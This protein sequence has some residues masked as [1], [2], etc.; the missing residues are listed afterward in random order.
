MINKAEG[1]LDKAAKVGHS[2]SRCVRGEGKIR[3]CP[4]PLQTE[5][6]LCDSPPRPNP[7]GKAGPGGFSQLFPSR[8]QAP[9][10]ARTTMANREMC[11][12]CGPSTEAPKNKGVKDPDPF[13]NSWVGPCACHACFKNHLHLDFHSLHATATLLLH[14][15]PQLHRACLLPAPSC[16]ASPTSLRVAL[17]LTKTNK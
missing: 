16:P 7:A 11:P 2:S 3:R 17:V 12:R 10:D 1:R 9:C 4:V 5:P 14:K 15:G 8:A 6:K 13:A